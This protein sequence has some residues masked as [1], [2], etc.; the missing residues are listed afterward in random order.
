MRSI[1][2]L[3]FCFLSFTAKA[4]TVFYD[5]SA[6]P[7]LGKISEATATRYERLPARLQGVSRSLVWDLGK[8]TAGLAI[9]FLFRF[10]KN[11]CEMG[12]A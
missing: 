11:L 5:A 12:N 1:F 7:L 3:L 9:R 4:Q 6:F 10:P 2:V 8:N